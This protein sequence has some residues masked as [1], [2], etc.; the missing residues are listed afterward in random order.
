MCALGYVGVVL[1]I[2]ISSSFEFDIDV[3][4]VQYVYENDHATDRTNGQLQSMYV[5]TRVETGERIRIE[6]RALQL[7]MHIY[8]H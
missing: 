8:V 2:F 6:A 1:A 5:C 7:H 4:I 3:A